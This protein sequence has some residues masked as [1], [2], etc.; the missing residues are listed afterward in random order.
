ML[1]ILGIVAKLTY[2]DMMGSCICG[3]KEIEKMSFDS[4]TPPSIPALC[5]GTNG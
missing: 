3:Q 1:L 4:E 5:C 2:F